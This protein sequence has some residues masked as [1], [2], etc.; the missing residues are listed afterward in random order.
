MTYSKLSRD[1][2]GFP[3]MIPE[4]KVFNHLSLF[5]TQWE[6]KGYS[7]CQIVQDNGL[8]KKRITKK[9]GSSNLLVNWM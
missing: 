6:N 4:R 8:S 2:G 5:D 9:S 1:F 3:E 7:V